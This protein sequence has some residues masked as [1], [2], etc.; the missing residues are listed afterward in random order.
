MKRPYLALATFALVAG[1]SPAT[2]LLPRA[3]ADGLFSSAPVNAASFAVL[4][5]PVGSDDWNLVVLEQQRA[6]PFCWTPRPD[7]LVDPTLNRFD[8]TGICGRFIDSNGFSLR[9]G[10]TDLNHAYRLRLEQQRGELRLLAS[11]PSQDRELLVGRGVI[12]RRDRDLFVSLQLEPGWDLRRRVFGGRSLNHIY[13]NNPEPLDNLI[14]AS[15]GR[16]PEALA[17]QEEDQAIPPMVP[18]PLGRSRQDRAASFPPTEGLRPA[19]SRG[20]FRTPPAAAPADGDA[21]TDVAAEAVSPGVVSLQVI[22]YRERISSEVRVQPTS[23]PYA[24]AQ[25]L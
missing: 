13:F 19:L 22:P 4:A 5:R 17:R 24:Q 10:E 14:A 1:A 9:I 20:Q 15:R 25:G 2:G 16:A 8:F 11:S 21:P 6:R 3:W 12:P 23:D 18:P 7:G